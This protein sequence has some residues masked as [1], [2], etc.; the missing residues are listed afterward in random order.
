VE[1]TG[2][3]H[4]LTKASIS[5]YVALE[6]KFDIEVEWRDGIGSGLMT[7]I[8]FAE[9]THAR[10]RSI[11]WFSSEPHLRYITLGVDDEKVLIIQ[12]QDE[13]PHVNFDMEIKNPIRN[14]FIDYVKSGNYD[15]NRQKRIERGY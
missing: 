2:K 5:K 4:S 12:D 14:L 1:V 3:Y 6:D 10:I 11:Q 15:A 8:K 13:D 9:W 7:G